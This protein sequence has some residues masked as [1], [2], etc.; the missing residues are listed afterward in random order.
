MDRAHRIGQTKPVLVFRFAS[1]NTV[2]QTI[3]ANATRK[4]KLE[5]VVLG[6]D[7][8]AGDSGAGDI[9]N[10]AK[11]KKVTNKNDNMRMLAEQLANAEGEKITL[12]G[13]GAEIL[14]DEQLE[15]RTFVQPPPPKTFFR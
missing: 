1:A 7:D 6:T 10:K 13:A 11:G 14:T 8:L 9:L 5:R 3:L 4:R 12:A 2:E 15:A